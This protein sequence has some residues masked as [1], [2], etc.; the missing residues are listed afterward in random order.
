MTILENALEAHQRCR[1]PSG[2]NSPSPNVI[3][4][5]DRIAVLAGLRHLAFRAL[6]QAGSP[7]S[8][9]G[10]PSRRGCTPMLMTVPC[11]KLS[12]VM[13]CRNASAALSICTT[14][15]SCSPFSSRTSAS[16]VFVERHEVHLEVGGIRHDAHDDAREHLVDAAVVHRVRM[17]RARR[18]PKRRAQSTP[19]NA[20]ATRR[21]ISWLSRITC[22]SSV[23]RFT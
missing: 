18:A 4:P 11:G 19:I 22:H 15:T 3:A 21:N 6:E 13:P 12:R 16:R 1:G 9:A 23:P 5:F 17:M 14:H 7:R 8:P 20:A 10:L 2:G